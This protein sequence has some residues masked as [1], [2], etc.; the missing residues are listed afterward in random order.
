MF[1]DM[2]NYSQLSERLGPEEAY[3]IMDQVYEILIHKVHDYEGTVNEMTGDGI[4]ALFGAPIALEDAPQRAIRS[5][6]AIHREMTKFSDKCKHGKEDIPSLKMRIGIHTGPV[7]VG[8]L[9]NDLRV[10]FKAVGDTVNLASRIEG[11]AEPGTTWVT[12]DTFRLTE[13]LF[14]FEYQGR[15]EVK[16]KAE[17]V[18]VYRVIAPSSMRTRFD[19]ST[20]RGL[21]PFV[22]R[23]RE[24]ELLLDCFERAKGGRGQACSILA[25]AGVGKSRLLYE[26]RKA[27]ANEEVTFL[28]GKCLSYSRGIPYHLQIDSLKAN[29]DIREG[30]KDSEIRKKVEKGLRILGADETATLPYLLELLSV[31]DSGIDNLSLS[32]EARKTRIVDAFKQIVLKGSEIRPLILANEDLHWVDKSSEDLLAHI[33]ESI[34]GARVFFIFTYR[35]DFVHTWG[36]KSFHSQVTL[37]R[38][39]NRESLAMVAHILGTDD[40]ERDLEELILEKTEG[41]PFFIEEFL[42]S[43]KDLK[44]IEKRD[45]KYYLTKEIK[46]LAIPSAIQDMIMARVDSLPEGGKDIL[47]TGSVAGREFTHRLIEIMMGLSERD[48]LS[49]LSLLKDAELVYE[50]GIYPQSTYIF[51]HALIQDATYQSLMKNTRQKYHRKIAQVLEKH[52]PESV[53]TQPEFLAY[54]YTEA[55]LNDQAA[56]YWQQAGKRAAQRSAHVEAISHLTT[57]L[58][59]LM[60][61]PDTIE[62][63]R[64]ELE[65]LTTLGP[66]LMAVKGQSSPDTERAYARA[67][68]LCQKLGETPQLCPVLYGLFRF[69]MVRAELRT[70][71]E[72]AEQ[73]FTLAQRAQDPALLLEANR[74][75]GQAMVWLGELVPGRAH[76]EQGMS[77]YDPQKHRSHAIVY[78]Q[79]P[80]VLC[81]SFAAMSIWMLGYPDQSLQNVRE[82]LNLAQEFNHPFSLALALALVSTVHQFRRE[83]QAVQEGAEAAI[84]VSTKH[85]FPQWLANGT[86]LRGWALSARGDGAEGIALIHQGLAARQAADLKIQRS[87]FLCLLAEAYGRVG[88]PEEGLKVL[89]EALATV[90]N[91]GE[92]Y[93]E[94]ELH[95]GKGELLLMQN[96]HKAGEVEECFQRA[97]ETARRQQAKSLELRAAM[98][99]SRLWQQQGKQEEAHE[100]LAE[101]YGWFT[102]GFDTLDLKEAKAILEELTK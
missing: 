92:R 100:R 19:V 44:I 2:E 23:E 30:E 15:K 96:G 61:L 22:G 37:N 36:A 26:F 73:F 58:E 35:P 38:L 55:G 70:A 5:A 40:L 84:A 43:L 42:K 3:G 72:L 12:D 10:E 18:H 14:R 90:D 93:C 13:G 87:Y 28:E 20:D 45:D 11:L 57:G 1:C 53:E 88:Q 63:A 9:G 81:R 94:A 66:V 16:G 69:H 59:V 39:S 62:R 80:D 25:E 21:T 7:V 33:L 49:H 68:D 83:V 91:T 29:F 97:L 67:R 8:T 75:L 76:L 31:K 102:E 79:D 32:P 99:L 101:I 41:I 52:F 51:K 95:R 24:L 46:D 54:H 89:V 82:A 17:P 27:V 50:R 85:G 34:P 74:N 56:G 48:L 78:G 60:T 86:I 71:R 6:L 77:L 4:M 65:M 64:Q 47:Q 98:S